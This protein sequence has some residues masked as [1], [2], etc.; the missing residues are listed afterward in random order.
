MNVLRIYLKIIINTA[1][2]LKYFQ[3]LSINFI[4][5]KDDTD[6]LCPN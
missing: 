5:S 2:H 4:T 6:I 1:L 3:K